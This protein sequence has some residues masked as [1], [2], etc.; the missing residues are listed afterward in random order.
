MLARLPWQRRAWPAC[1]NAFHLRQ[2]R[3][4]L[5]FQ[6]GALHGVIFFAQL[7]GLVFKV[8]VAQVLVGC[9]LALAEIKQAGL[10]LA[11]IDVARLIEHVDEQQRGKQSA[12]EKHEHGLLS[13]GR[14]GNQWIRQ[15]SVS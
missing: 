6:R 11:G 12:S 9:V 7:A 14:G 3:G 15:N 8:E 2:D 4:G 1:L 10:G 5:V 13:R